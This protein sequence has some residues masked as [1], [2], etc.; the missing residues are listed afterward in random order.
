M[1]QTWA[2]VLFPPPPSSHSQQ[3][4]IYPQLH[5][6]TPDSRRVQSKIPI[7]LYPTTPPSCTA[8]TLCAS[9]ALPPPRRSRTRLHPR[10]PPRLA[11]S[12]A[13]PTLVC[14]ITFAEFSSP[15]WANCDIYRPQLPQVRPPR[16][17]RP[18]SC[19]EALPA[20]EDGE[21]RHALHGARWP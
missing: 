5:L 21:E 2:N 8:P 17:F 4:S 6:F 13:R 18:R 16:C 7:S 9:R 19:E 10:P 12:S 15:T 11:G 14:N 3:Q 20:R 1:H